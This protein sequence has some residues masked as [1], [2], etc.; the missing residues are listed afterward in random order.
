MEFNP[1]TLILIRETAGMRPCDVA[2]KL[3]FSRQTK[4]NAAEQNAMKPKQ[5]AE[6]SR[7]PPVA[8]GSKECA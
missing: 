2:E 4:W 1:R 5:N 6:R 8:V 7:S 3:S